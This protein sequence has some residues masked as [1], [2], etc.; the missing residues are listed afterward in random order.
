MA[1]RPA[2]TGET[3][4]DWRLRHRLFLRNARYLLAPSRDVVQR[5][6]RYFASANLRFAP[7]LDLTADS[8]LPQPQ[9]RRLSATEHLRVLV[10]GA[11]NEVKGADTLE[12]VALQAARHSAPFEFHLVGYAHRPLKTQPHA[13][14]TVHGAYADDDLP[15]LLERLRPDVVWFPA[16]WPETY[17]YTLSACLLA[18]VPIMAPNLGAFPERL[19]QRRWTWIK[20]WDTTATA[21]MDIFEN[22]RRQHFVTGQEP[23]VTAQFTP[24]SPDANLAPWS[25]ATDYLQGLGRLKP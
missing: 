10:I 2:P 8:V 19:S 6:Q 5:M 24:A 1:Q 22:L 4:E 20:P 3:I 23:P 16:R 7:H 25:Y 11:V 15:R 17:S 18:G 21:W 14:L 13:S 9:P 12:A